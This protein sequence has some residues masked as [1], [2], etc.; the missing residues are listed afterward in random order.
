V[1]FVHPVIVGKP[2]L[3]SVAVRSREAA[4]RL[5]SAALSGDVVV[6]IGDGGD[7]AIADVV[8]RAPAWGVESIWLAFGHPPPGDT[9]A[10]V[11]WLGAD[12]GQADVVC[13]YHLLW[14]LTHVCLEHPGV[15]EVGPTGDTIS[16]PACMDAGDL[17]EIQSL[18]CANDTDA[19]VM[20][21]GL[22]QPV[23]L[24][25]VGSCEPGDLIVVHAGVALT[26]LAV[27]VHD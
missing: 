8:Q 9:G 18:G 4:D 21:G 3:P 25:L 7:L 2:A 19:A 17:G 24:S 23:D 11:V 10:H 12:A 27:S 6:V 26:K 14:E 16:C 13:A 15:L 20:V 1:E 5:R 22:T